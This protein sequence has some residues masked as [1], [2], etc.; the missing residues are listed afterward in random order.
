MFCYL[1][2]IQIS[3]AIYILERR[4]GKELEEKIENMTP[5]L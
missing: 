1:L 3:M 4:I 5:K 2:T